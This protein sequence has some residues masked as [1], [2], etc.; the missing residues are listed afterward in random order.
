MIE[1]NLEAGKRWVERRV[2][3]L[4]PLYSVV[5]KGKFSWSQLMEDKI[6]LSFVGRGQQTRVL[7]DVADL[8]RVTHDVEQTKSNG[9]LR[10]NLENKIEQAL[11][12]IPGLPEK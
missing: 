11:V 7:F 4:A 9:K 1:S 10:L 2:E 12:A 8:E 6:D 5:I 3:L